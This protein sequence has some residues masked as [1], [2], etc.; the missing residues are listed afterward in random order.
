MKKILANIITLL[1]EIICLILCVLWFI[2]GNGSY[3][4]IITGIGLIVSIFISTSLRIK[5]DRDKN[6]VG[7]ES[8]DNNIVIQ[9]NKG[10]I[11]IEK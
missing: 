9:N 2:F 7:I 11:S 4:A 1:A 8:S 10:K 5:K 3:E 6:N